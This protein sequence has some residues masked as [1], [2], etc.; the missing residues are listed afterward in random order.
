MYVDMAVGE[1]GV[2]ESLLEGERVDRVVNIEKVKK[3]KPQAR[4][5]VAAGQNTAAT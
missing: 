4:T 1:A 5:A 3:T 2:V